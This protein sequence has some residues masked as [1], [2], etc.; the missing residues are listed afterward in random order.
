MTRR[1]RCWGLM[2]HVGPFD[3]TTVRALNLA[4]LPPLLEVTRGSP[5]VLVGLVD[6]PVA[7]A[8]PELVDAHIRELS[9]KSPGTCRDTDSTACNHG[10]FVAG[11]LSARRTSGAPGLCPNCTLL[12]RPIF[13]ETI[14]QNELTPSA[15]PEE[16]TAALIDCVAEGAHIVN[17]SAYLV[18]PDWR[19]Q[20]EL[21]QA[22]NFAAQRRTMIVAAAGNLGTVQ[23]SVITQHRWVIPVVSCDLEGHPSQSSTLSPSVG[24]RGL[25]APG[26]GITS[27]GSDGSL[28][29][30]GGSSAAAAFVTGT[31]ALLLSV[32]PKASVA[33][34]KVAV[35]QNFA[36][37]ST[38]ILPPLLDARAAYQSLKRRQS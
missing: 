18:R 29:A 37:R 6:G 17:L 20:R 5:E 27:L 31:I 30:S 23:S 25:R 11:I 3:D 8:H 12:V 38:A 21:E 15:L 22:I 1:T 19:R 34:V 26:E 36:T 16:L 24:R 7:I 9:D 10:T 32:F 14:G 4:R 35:T 33:E 2:L 28:V 13:T